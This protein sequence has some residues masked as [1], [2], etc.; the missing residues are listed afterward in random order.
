MDREIIRQRLKFAQ[1][2]VT[3]TITDIFGSNVPESKIRY[4]VKI[5]VTGDQVTTRVLTLYKKKEDGTYEVFVPNISVPAPGYKEIP[6]GGISLE[7]PILT[8]EGGTNIAGRVD[9]NSLS[10]TVVYWD[11]DV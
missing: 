4:V 2:Q 11:N 8:L 5:I 7:D 9:G 6:E 3:T 10:V 1:R